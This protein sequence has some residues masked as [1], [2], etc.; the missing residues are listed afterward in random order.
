MK[1]IFLGT[2]TSMGVPVIGC[3]CMVCQS[4]DPR[5][6][7]LRSSI[8]VEWE[9]ERLLIDCGPD[10]RE[11]MLRYN[12]ERPTALLLTHEHFD[13]VG[14]LD[15]LRPFCYPDPLPI[16]AEGYVIDRIRQRMPYC[17]ADQLYPGAPRFL[18]KEVTLNSF[19]IGGKKIVPIR[20]WHH[21][22]PILGYRLQNMAYITDVK[23]I[24]EEEYTKL[25]DLDL[26]IIDALRWNKEHLSHQTIEQALQVIERISPQTAYLIH[27]NHDAGLHIDT[28]N[29]LPT[30]V[31]LAFDGLQLEI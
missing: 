15:D 16:Y 1:I 12:S 11:Q 13:H 27:M 24:P 17:F 19:E 3:K 22:L 23:E 9:S 8:L 7:R 10:F 5:D 20:V 4:T 29:K 18:M 30:G 28:E 2:G 26:L 21:H 31:Y 14:G 25:Q 6:K